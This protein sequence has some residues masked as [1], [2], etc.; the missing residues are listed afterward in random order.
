MIHIVGVNKGPGDRIH[1]IVAKRDSAL[2]RTCACARNIECGDGAV[3]SAHEAMIDIVRVYVISRDHAG[4]ADVLGCGALVG[5]CARARNV[6]R[7]DGAIRGAHDPVTYITGVNVGA[8]NGSSL[9]NAKGKG[10][11]WPGP[12]PAPGTSNVVIVPSGARRTP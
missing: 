12:V 3:L 2:L 7:G 1:G 5:A 11:L 8:L 4:R 10:A 6:K 9:V